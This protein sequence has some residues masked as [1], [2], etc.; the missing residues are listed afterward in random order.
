DGFAADAEALFAKH[1]AL[2]EDQ[3]PAGLAALRSVV[4]VKLKQPDEAAALR[5]KALAVPGARVSVAYRMMVDSQLAKLKPADKRAAETLF[6][7]ELAKPPT[8]L[9]VNQL[10]AAY[11]VYHVEGLTYRGQ[12]THEKKLL[13][14]VEKCLTADVPESD[15]ERLGEMLVAKQEWKYAKKYLDGCRRRFPKN[16]CF[17]VLAAETAIGKE[18]RFFTVD[19]L[20]LEAKRLAEAATEPRHKLLLERIARI[21]KEINTPFDIGDFFGDF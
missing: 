4:A 9:E 5:A 20:L 14:Q 15:F 2:L 19:R 10:I 11:D 13:D 3:T 12:K 17:L 16:P 7:D 1:R 8:P 21:Q 18:E 6:A